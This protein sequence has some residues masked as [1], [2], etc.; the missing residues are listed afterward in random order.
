ML[1]VGFVRGQCLQN[2][3]FADFCGIQLGTCPTFNTPCVPNWFRSHGTPQI[4]PGSPAALNTAYMWALSNTQFGVENGEGI[5]A[6]YTFTA[7]NVYTITLRAQLTSAG[8]VGTIKLAATTGLT[9]NPAS[10]SCGQVPPV[11]STQQLIPFTTFINQGWIEYVISFIPTSNYSQIWIHPTNTSTTDILNL[12]VDYLRVCRDT[13]LAPQIF[14][15]GTVPTGS[16]KATT[17]EAGSTAGSGGS[18]TVNVSA[19]ATTLLRGGTEVVLLPEFV[20]E[21]TTGLFEA[22]IETCGGGGGSSRTAPIDRNI[23]VSK[24]PKTDQLYMERQDAT[25]KIYLYPNPARDMLTAEFYLDPGDP[26]E[27]KVMTATGATVRQIKRAA[28]SSR[29]MQ[30]VQIPIAGLPKGIYFVQ[31]INKKG[32]TVRKIEKME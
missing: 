6:P 4:M 10:P 23:D 19:T 30:R 16:T 3:D 11:P 20:A 12:Y 21:P 31:I 18:G 27:I 14:N 28:G 22:Y 17:I 24:F 8:T 15:T 9:E 1:S 25:Q 32:V 7:N 26:V 29:E 5:F 2:S 13:C